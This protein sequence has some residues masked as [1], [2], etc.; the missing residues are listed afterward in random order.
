MFCHWNDISNGY[1]FLQISGTRYGTYYGALENDPSDDISLHYSIFDDPLVEDAARNVLEINTPPQISIS[2][3]CYGP[4]ILHYYQTDCGEFKFREFKKVKKKRYRIKVLN[5]DCSS[6][7]TIHG[8]DPNGNYLPSVDG[9]ERLFYPTMKGTHSFTIRQDNK[10][11][12]PYG[13]DAVSKQINVS[14]FCC[15]GTTTNP[16]EERL[17]NGNSNDHITQLNNEDNILL[18]SAYP[19]PTPDNIELQLFLIQEEQIKIILTNSFG[20]TIKTFESSTFDPGEH[21][22]RYDLSDLPSGVYFLNISSKTSKSQ[23]IKLNKID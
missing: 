19:N 13:V 7:Y 11:I 20:Q 4:V 9:T 14:L 6:V 21:T 18:L 17:I 5:P 23:S 15:L 3:E 1:G 10:L 8:S 2:S 12:A 16:F 22:L